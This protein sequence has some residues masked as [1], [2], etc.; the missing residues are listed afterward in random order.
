MSIFSRFF[1]KKS[2]IRSYQLANDVDQ[3]CFE[4]DSKIIIQSPTL[5]PFPEEIKAPITSL[6]SQFSIV[7]S[8]YLVQIIYLD[9]PDMSPRSRPCL[10]LLYEYEGE[11]DKNIHDMISIQMQKVIDGKLGEWAF[12]DHSAANQ[13]LICSARKVVRPFYIKK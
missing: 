6:L 5:F 1:R 9:N 8:A 2:G 3:L 7:L 13:D 10:T 12:L 4:R 11:F